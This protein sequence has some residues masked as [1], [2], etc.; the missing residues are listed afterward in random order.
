VRDA[1]DG[2]DDDDGTGQVPKKPRKYVRKEKKVELGPDGQSL[3]GADAN[4]TPTT[5]KPKRKYTKRKNA[6]PTAQV[7]EGGEL[8]VDLG[9]YM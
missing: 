7:V 2:D 8:N 5:P 9:M 3:A 4:G 6:V 1:D